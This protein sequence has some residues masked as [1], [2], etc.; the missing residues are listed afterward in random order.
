MASLR[1]HLAS[2]GLAVVFCH[3]VMQILVP[4]ALCCQKPVV[5]ARVRAEARECCP[6]GSHPGQIC[7]MHAKNAEKN[8]RKS[9]DSCSATPLVDLHDMLM[10]LSSAGVVPAIA[11][12]AIV[13]RAE[14]APFAAAL[15]PSVVASAPPGPPPR[16]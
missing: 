4:A 16:A 1:R 3:T 8:T 7:P 13:L 9:G 2:L 6:A 5:G 10:T 15:I 11:S 14:S 12:F